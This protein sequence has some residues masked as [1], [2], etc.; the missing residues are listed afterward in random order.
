MSLVEN[1][2]LAVPIF[3]CYGHNASCQLQYSPRR[4]DGIGLT[5]GEGL[6]RLWSYLRD[7]ARITKEMGS[8]KRIDALTD[9]LIYYG[10]RIVQR[11]GKWLEGKLKRAKT[12]LED[13]ERSFTEITAGI[14]VSCDIDD[15]KSWMSEEAEMLRPKEDVLKLQWDEEYVDLLLEEQ[16]IRTELTYVEMEDQHQISD[17][18]KKHKSK[19]KAITAIERRNNIKS[20]WLQN[21]A[22]FQNTKERLMAKK[23]GMIKLKLQRMASERTFLLEMQKKYADGQSIAIRLSKQLTKIS[24][25]MKKCVLSYNAR[26]GNEETLSFEDVKDPTGVVFDEFSSS[27]TADSIPL[28]VKRKLVDMMLLKY[29][30]KEEIALVKEEMLRFQ[31]FHYLQKTLISEHLRSLEPSC[32]NRGLCSLLSQKHALLNNMQVRVQHLWGQ[33]FGIYF[34]YYC[35]FVQTFQ[36]LGDVELEQSESEHSNEELLDDTINDSDES[37]DE[38]CDSDW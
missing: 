17:L 30:C 38:D 26:S 19:E 4:V 22:S 13:I 1:V 16:K 2:G 6:E 18:Q 7:F 31:R 8:A 3:H 37:S 12:T 33:Q 29:R 32:F 20:C 23:K 28:S 15:V 10:E 9:A 21:D 11:S 14:S 36:R 24:L 25:A 27:L 34:P 5:D 35:E